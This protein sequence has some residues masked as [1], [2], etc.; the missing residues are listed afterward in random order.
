MDIVITIIVVVILIIVILSIIL[1]LTSNNESNNPVYAQYNERCVSELNTNST[2]PLCDLGLICTNGICKKA[3]GQACIDDQE[4]TTGLTCN[5][6]FCNSEI[7]NLESKIYQWSKPLDNDINGNWTYL[8]T[9]KSPGKNPCLTSYDPVGIIYAPDVSI[10]T[11]KN[12][13]YYLLQNN[14]NIESVN[15]IV[16]YDNS[17][18]TIIPY[19][20]HFLNDGTLAL[21]AKLVSESFSIN[22]ILYAKL[23]QN[24]IVIQNLPTLAETSSIVGS[25]INTEIPKD[26]SLDI[27]ET[28]LA[29]LYYNNVIYTATYP[30]NSLNFPIYNINKLQLTGNNIGYTIDSL[31]VNQIT[32]FLFENVK[33]GS[34]YITNSSVSQYTTPEAL[35][36]QQISSSSYL[37]YIINEVDLKLSFPVNSFSITNIANTNSEFPSIYLLTI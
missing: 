21:L 4:C 33:Y 24:S 26:F 7:I 30:S 19:N 14:T 5:N 13:T 12:Y 6:G 36:I 29:L 27:T 15:L 1:A 17:I 32:S 34:P 11:S 23:E 28:N 31:S 35:Y 20:I 8:Y 10:H 9:V 16:I 37:H 3:S 18:F 25:I 22:Y 2:F